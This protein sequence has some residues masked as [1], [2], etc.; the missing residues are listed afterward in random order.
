MGKKSGWNDRGGDEGG[1]PANQ[2][3]GSEQDKE[4]LKRGLTRGDCQLKEK[5]WGGGLWIWGQTTGDPG[6]GAF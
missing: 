4:K 2:G 3:I 6:E 1:V 5:G